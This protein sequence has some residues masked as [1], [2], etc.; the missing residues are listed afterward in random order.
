MSRERERDGCCEP[1]PLLREQNS[2]SLFWAKTR[3]FEV[4]N[5]LKHP[6]CKMMERSF[7]GRVPTFYTEDALNFKKTRC[8]GQ[9]ILL[10]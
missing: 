4:I 10:P 7:F 3:L 1:E 9:T 8:E 5:F 6:L 2:L